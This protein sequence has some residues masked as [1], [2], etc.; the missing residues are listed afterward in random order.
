MAVFSTNQNHHLFVANEY[1]AATTA[2]AAKTFADG[3]KAGTIAVRKLAKC[4]EPTIYFLYKGATTPLKSDYIPVKNISYIKAKPAKELRVPFKTQVV[5]LDANV[6]GG[7]PIVGQDYILRIELTHWVGM[8]E[9]DMYFKEAAVH[10]FANMSA[11]DF[12][13]AMVKSLNLSFSREIGATPD[14]NPY[15][16]FTSSE[17][18]IT[19]TEKAQD[20]SLGI[21]A[22]EPVLFNAVSTT[23][24]CNGSDV[25]WGVTKTTTPKVANV[26][27]GTNGIGDGHKIA[28]MEWFCMGERGDQYRMMGYPNYIPTKY[29]VD[30]EK[31]YHVLDIHYAY[32]DEG[33]HSYRSEKDLS[34]VS[35]DAATMNSIITAIADATG[36]SAETIVDGGSIA[37]E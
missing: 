9:N 24:Y 14:S 16:D 4:V 8:S 28:D 7:A 13:D 11:K 35:A 15:L 21:E 27:P 6:N 34:I 37:T 22:Q 26:T 36:I 30:P 31:E 18:G 33:T 19:I 25:Q 10:V 5:T 3:A 2:E 12:Y 17:E 29:L 20:W 1:K 32:T 23:V